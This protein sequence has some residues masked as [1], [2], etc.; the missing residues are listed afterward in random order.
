MPLGRF[1]RLQ[2]IQ[3]EIGQRI[4]SALQICTPVSRL[5]TKC[6]Q[7]FP[8]QP[9]LGQRKM[10][11]A[12]GSGRPPHLGKHRNTTFEV[13]DRG[14]RPSRLGDGAERFGPRGARQ[15]GQRL[16]PQYIQRSGDGSV[17]QA[18]TRPTRRLRR[19]GS[20]STPHE[21]MPLTN[22]RPSSEPSQCSSITS[23]GLAL[24]R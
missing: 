21:A 22:S 10:T 12:F 4:T 3:S 19:S 18:Q 17:D 23:S 20:I 2:R 16:T 13:L 1:H 24:S 5:L 15:I 9:N 6:S 11:D 14:N 7:T 8:S